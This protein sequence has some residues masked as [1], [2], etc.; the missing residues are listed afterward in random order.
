VYLAGGTN[1]RVISAK[2]SPRVR[3]LPAGNHLTAVHALEVP[4]KGL[5]YLV[6]TALVVK[7][8]DVGLHRV[9]YGLS[10]LLVKFHEGHVS[11]VW[12]YGVQRP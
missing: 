2:Y 1:R 6:M 3:L 5:V 7:V 4:R 8:V 9:A 11:G 12:D 10:V